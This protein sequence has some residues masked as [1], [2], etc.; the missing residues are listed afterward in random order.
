MNRLFYFYPHCF[1]KSTDKEVLVYDTMSKLYVYLK[2]SP[3]SRADRETFQ[4][5]YVKVSESLN[6]FV[7]LCLSNELGYFVEFERVLP[8]FESRGLEFV[9]SLSKERKALGY[10][11]HSH[12]NS[13]LREVTIQLKNS[14]DDY[15]DEMCLQIEY[16]KFNNES[17]NLDFILQQLSSFQYL[18]NIIIAGEIEK[19]ELEKT[20]KYAEDYNIRVVHRIMFDSFNYALELKLIDRYDIF[21]IELLIDNSVDTAKIEHLSQDKIY[22]KA[23]GLYD[24]GF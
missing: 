14:K 1:L 20:L 9:T 17:I 23:I 8:F 19:S 7:N 3:L 12:T 22:V 6:D 11:L 18:E 15:S 4:M 5:G 13:I 21:S 10:N 2:A 16:P 24:I